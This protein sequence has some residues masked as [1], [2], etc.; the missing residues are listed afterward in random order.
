MHVTLLVIRLVLAAVFLVAGAAKL[1]DPTG[2][3]AAATGFGVPAPV[4]GVVGVLL[5]LAELC[6]AGAL[7]PASSA[8]YGALAAAVLLLAFVAAITR[9]IARGEAPDCHC[10]GAIHS[11]P[12]GARTLARNALLLALAAAVAAVGWGNAGP[13]AV[14]WVGQLHGA[15]LVAAGGGAALL[16]LAALTVA[17]LLTLLRQ[18]RRLLLRVDELEAHLE[19]AGPAGPAPTPADHPGLPIGSPAPAFSLAGL[20]G[21]TITLA[22][23]T[24][25]DR[26]LLLLFTDP[27]CG[28][29]NA[30]LPS[31]ARWQ[32]A[33]SGELTI[34][35]LTRGSAA[36][37][38]PKAREHGIA[39]V[40]LDAQLEVYSACQA[41]GTPGAVLVDSRGRIA[42]PVV[43]GA[44]SIERLID[45]ALSGA[46]AAPVL[47]VPAPAVAVA[48]GAGDPAP[49]LELRDGDGDA[50]SL[51][52]PDRDTLVLFWNP[53]C[54][55]CA[56]MLPDLLAWE[57]ARSADAPR[58]LV[59][60]AGT[61]AENRAMG[62]AGELV[63]DANF[64]AGQAFGAAGTP[65]AVLVDSA[66][67]IASGVAV[68]APSVLSLAA[69][70]RG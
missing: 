30:L 3:R 44:A 22:S 20:Y 42:S 41:I 54:G 31:I 27:G 63:L 25:R 9:S 14:H 57:R 60:A 50:V 36:D 64:S 6:T 13:S 55:F 35:V 19:G 23:L 70:V 67:R 10:F 65:S 48:P 68:G 43:G 8:R 66:G 56:R 38:L 47:Q 17:G 46:G 21:E 52:D 33:H 53:G 37:Y 62:L 34:A 69:G 32:Q 5:P 11:E 12:A 1:A 49:S 15:G 26:P 29:C 2:S 24:A 7:L 45:Q 18:N 28:P 16:A 58:L 59:I 4:A 39:G 51:S 61:L 40:L